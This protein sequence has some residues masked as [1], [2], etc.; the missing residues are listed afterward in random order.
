MARL[1]HL[2]TFSDKRGKLTV[3]E[4]VLPFD[5]RRIF[6]IYDV[7]DSV[8]GGHRHKTTTQAAVCIKGSCKIFNNNGQ[9]KETFLLDNPEKC[10]I[11][12]PADWHQMLEFTPDA[13]LMVMASSEFDIHDYIFEPYD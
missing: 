3:I 12:E 9:I 10:L 8:R 7:D 1:I 2:N 13:V 5:V 11:L 4:K 6:Y